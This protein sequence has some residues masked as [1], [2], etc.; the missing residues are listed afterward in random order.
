MRGLQAIG[1]PRKGELLSIDRSILFLPFPPYL[2]R[3]W[4]KDDKEK[5]N[6]FLKQDAYLIKR[7]FYNT[8]LFKL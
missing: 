1:V 6:L 2:L 4:L 5:Q 7:K 8:R 3:T